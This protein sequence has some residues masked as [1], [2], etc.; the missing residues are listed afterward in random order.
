MCIPRVVREP[1]ENCFDDMMLAIPV[2]Q[3]EFDEIEEMEEID[4]DNMPNF[5]ENPDDEDDGE[6]LE[7]VRWIEEER[8]N[9][10]LEEH[11]INYCHQENWD[12]EAAHLICEV[13]RRSLDKPGITV[14]IVGLAVQ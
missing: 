10:R 5:L 8:V 14:D 7:Y 11:H 9:Q 13:C 4:V 12:P 6:I 2:L 1:I 3:F